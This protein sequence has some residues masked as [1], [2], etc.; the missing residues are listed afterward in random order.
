[1]LERQGEG[2]LI[3]LVADD[4]QS[5]LQRSLLLVLAEDA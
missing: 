1:V 4:N 3:L 2:R 5:P